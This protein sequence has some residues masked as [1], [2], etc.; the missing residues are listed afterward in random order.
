MRW[1]ARGAAVVALA[2]A[3]TALG[4]RL[5][6]PSTSETGLGAISVSVDV[7]WHGDVEVFIPIA[8][9]GIRVRP[10]SAPV[11]LHVEPRSVDRQAMIGL[12]SG[13]PGV[14]D[15]AERDARGAA[16]HALVRAALWSIGGALALGLVAALISV[17]LGS[18]RVPAAAW[19]FAPPA[20][21]GLLAI[22]VVL[23]AHATFEPNAFDSPSFYARGAEL[24]QLLRVAENAQET[25]DRYGSSVERALVGYATLLNAGTGR[26][27]PGT[28]PPALLASDLHDNG[29]AL[30]AVKRLVSGR[31]TFFVG[32]FGQRGTRA[33]ATAL[34]PQIAALG[35]RIV[36]VSGNHDSRSF[37]RRLARA[38]VTVL[39]ARGRLHGD[40]SLGAKAVI[41]IAGLHVAGHQDPLEWRR[42]DPDRPTRVF[43]F[44]ELPDPERARGR[45][46]GSLVRWFERLRPR[47]DVVLVHQNG[48][49]QHLAA[50]AR[51]DGRRRP[52]LIL[53][54]HDH[55]QHIDRYGR[56]LVVDGGTVGAG[57]AFG[58]GSQSVG[59]A[60]L[61]LRPGRVRPRAVDLIQVEPLSGA[62]SAERIITSSK[63]ACAREQ[64]RCHR[65][66][67]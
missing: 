60:E 32:D 19:I 63:H 20:C 55:R 37:M 8:D 43:S 4:L 25:G 44:D 64:V 26:D 10:Y 48:L 14:L 27:T 45:A 5:A 28:R 13:A 2:A 21:A 46:E 6:G 11:E 61:H 23:R 12:A 57:G 33:E 22:G 9:W 17:A 50:E 58:V 47:P 7:A 36:A 30:G 65:R 66:D 31:P 1:L 29:L 54:G 34:I 41:R 35:P 52:L 15:A 59:L 18:G 38:G 39:T 67:E 62:A 40:G 24:G 56:V 51:G 49:A 3:G 16:R 42:P 53:T